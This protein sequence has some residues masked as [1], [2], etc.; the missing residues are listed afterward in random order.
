LEQ[1]V[2][3]GENPV[4]DFRRLSVVPRLPRVGLFGNAAQ[5]GW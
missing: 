2:V 4:R 1:E 3:E 5:N